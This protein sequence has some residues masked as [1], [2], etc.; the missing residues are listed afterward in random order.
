[1]DLSRVKFSSG[2]EPLVFTFGDLK[3]EG[4][5]ERVFPFTEKEINELLKETLREMKLSEYDIAE[6]NRKVERARRAS[7]FTREDYE[8]V[9]QNM[10]TTLSS[11]PT[12]NKVSNVLYA[13]V[14]Y[15]NSSSWMTSVQLPLIY[16]RNL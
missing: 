14:R 6:Y 2:S 15:M 16:L 9:K 12:F 3:V 10:E 8:R 11:I 1:M 13:I 5:V 7:E 4:A